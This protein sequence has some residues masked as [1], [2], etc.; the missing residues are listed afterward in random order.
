M[1]RKYDVGLKTLLQQG[2]A[3]QVFYGD[4]VLVYKYRRIV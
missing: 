3:E 1:T 2:I 4:L